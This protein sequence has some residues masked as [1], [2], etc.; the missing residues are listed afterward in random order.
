[1]NLYERAWSLTDKEYYYHWLEQHKEATIVFDQESRIALYAR[2]DSPV[3][4]QGVNTQKFFSR[5]NTVD[6]STH[7]STHAQDSSCVCEETPSPPEE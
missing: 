4:T 5:V 3:I 6:H 1:M 2:Y 7:E